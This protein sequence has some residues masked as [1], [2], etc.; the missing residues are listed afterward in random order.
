VGAAWAGLAGAIM[1]CTVSGKSVTVE[2][3][4]AS[5]IRVGIMNAASISPP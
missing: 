4:V 2:L 5:I 1:A 3:A